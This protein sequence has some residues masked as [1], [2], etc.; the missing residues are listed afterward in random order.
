MRNKRLNGSFLLLFNS[1]SSFKILNLEKIA[2]V[3]PQG[4]TSQAVFP[5]QTCIGKHLLC[6]KYGKKHGIT[7]VTR[8]QSPTL[9]TYI[10]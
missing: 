3:Q 7:V 10:F 6:C 9:A 2:T 8:I 4:R 5:T 1:S